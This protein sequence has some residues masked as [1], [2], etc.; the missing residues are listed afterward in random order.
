KENIEDRTDYRR[1]AR[2]IRFLAERYAEQPSL[3]DAADAAGLSAFHFQRTF[4]RYVGISPK[5]FVGH[6]TLEHATA[7]LAR[8]AS[9]LE[10]SLEAGLSGPSRLHDLTL[11]IEAMTPGESARGGEGL[12]IAYGFHDSPFGTVL[13]MM[14]EKG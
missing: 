4:T 6:L 2:A 5:S 12:T 9:V 1:I 3:E 7:E 11:K 13:I 10:A 8:G 14:T